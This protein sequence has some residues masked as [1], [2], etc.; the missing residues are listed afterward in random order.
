ME[1]ETEMPRRVGARER[2]MRLSRQQQHRPAR[3]LR[4]TVAPSTLLRYRGELVALFVWFAACGWAASPTVPADPPAYL[5]AALPNYVQHLYDSLAPLSRASYTLAAVQQLW[6]QLRGELKAAWRAV[7]AWSLTV[8]VSMRLP[9]GL[10]VV[11]AMAAAA[12]LL[13]WPR[14]GAGLLLAF[15]CLLRPGELVTLLRGAPLAT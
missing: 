6:P 14:V 9:L 8:P 1:G 13:G 2:A 15:R 7:H 5:P 11:R 12:S 10:E 4:I 3:D